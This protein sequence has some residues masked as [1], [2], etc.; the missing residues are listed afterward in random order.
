MGFLDSIKSLFGDGGAES[1]ASGYYV[2]VRC[3]RCGEPI[4]T[5]IDVRNE[6]SQRDEGGYVVRKTLVGNRRCFERIEVTLVF[7]AERRLAERTIE[8]GEFITAEEFGA[9]QSS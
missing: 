7:D 3:R 1:D 8:R 9:A 4:M 2:Y 6:L 5:R